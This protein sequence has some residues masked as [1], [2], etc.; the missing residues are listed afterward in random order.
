MKVSVSIITYNHEAFLA[1]ALESVL[2]QETDFD[3]E[4]IIGED[5]SSD[6]TP[7][8]AQSFKDKY[9]DKIQLFLN[10]RSNVIYVDGQATGKWN[11]NNNIVHAKGEYIAFLEGD[12]YWVSTDKLQKQIDF[13]EAN[14]HLSFCFH[15]ILLVDPE[16]K[17]LGIEK[18]PAAMK[19]ELSHE[20]IVSGFY[21]TPPTGSILYR[22][23]F[24]R[25]MPDWF[26]TFKNGDILIAIVLS[27]HGNAGYVPGKMSA[28]RIHG[29]GVWSSKPTSSKIKATIKM[30]KQLIAKFAPLGYANNCKLVIENYFY[31]LKISLLSLQILVFIKSLLDLTKFLFKHP[32]GFKISTNILFKKISHV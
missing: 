11:L 32:I 21:P 23:D 5:G 28:Y 16:G 15:D 18:L 24:L 14:P 25:A 17:D 9:P 8:V 1:Q 31:L 29:G 20:E 4:I 7:A 3:F 10:D 2:A 12:D 27:K 26:Y 19:K 22:G 13:L 30:R 6:N